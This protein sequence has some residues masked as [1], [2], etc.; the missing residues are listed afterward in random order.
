MSASLR[1]NCADCPQLSGSARTNLD[2]FQNCPSDPSRICLNGRSEN[3]Y[4]FGRGHPGGRKWCE[5]H[6]HRTDPETDGL[7]EKAVK[8]AKEGTST[9]L[10]QFGWMNNGGPMQW[11]AIILCTTFRIYWLMEILLRAQIRWAFCWTYFTTWS[12]SWISSHSCERVHPSAIKSS[13]ACFWDVRYQSKSAKTRKMDENSSNHPGKRTTYL[14]LQN[15]NKMRWMRRVI[16][17]VLLKTLSIDIMFKNDRN[18]V[19]QA[20]TFLTPLK[21]I[22]AVWRTNASLHVLQEHKMDECW[23]VDGD[24]KLSGP[25]TCF[26][27]ITILNHSPPFV[28]EATS[29]PEYKWSEIQSNMSHSLS[30]KKKVL[31]KKS[32]ARQYQK[33]ERNF[34]Y[35]FGRCGI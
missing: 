24:Q 27:L 6:R 5:V 23:N 12:N 25:W 3:N 20:R 19:L 33:I 17:G 29:R 26:T 8:S 9:V 2:K 14:I 10:V 32:E 21:Y 7:A 15:N 31:G 22:Y 11:N 34:S 18:F 1:I 4:F 30:R 35:S 16:S 13:E 28:R